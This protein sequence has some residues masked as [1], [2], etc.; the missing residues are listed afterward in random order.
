MI[1]YNELLNL[2][3]SKDSIYFFNKPLMF[4]T[5]S[6]SLSCNSSILGITPSKLFKI[7]KKILLQKFPKFDK[8]SLLFFACNSFQLN[9]V[10][11]DSGLIDA[12]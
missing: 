4:F 2:I 10:S 11:P 3:S 5:N 8:I 7:N 9:K 6:I 1:K 12:R